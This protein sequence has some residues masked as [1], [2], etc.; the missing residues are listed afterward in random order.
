MIC[1]KQPQ[2]TL[3]LAIVCR[4]DAEAV[5]VGLALAE[6]V[7]EAACGG[8]RGALL[9]LQAVFT[10]RFCLLTPLVGLQCVGCLPPSAGR[11]HTS[12]LPAQLC[13]CFIVISQLMTRLLPLP[14]VFTLCFYFLALLVG[15]QSVG[16]L[17]PSANGAHIIT[18][19]CVVLRFAKKSH[20]VSA[21]SNRL[22]DSKVLA[23][24]RPLQTVH[25]SIE[26]Q[27]IIYSLQAVFTVCFCPH[28]LLVGLQGVGCLPPSAIGAHIMT[29][30]SVILRF[31]KRSH[32]VFA[33]SLCC[34][35]PTCWLS[36]A[37]CRRCT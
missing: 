17:P 9:P 14:A 12:L 7:L 8:Q 24:C 5:K 26:K 2:G 25:I 23:V 11:E 28:T 19:I 6:T 36:A 37:L 30:I 4:A 22:L 18:A 13:F 21:F 10:L 29:A 20:S 16:C 34:W 3:Y 33:F 1:R 32:S 15:F 31:A 35:T 27:R